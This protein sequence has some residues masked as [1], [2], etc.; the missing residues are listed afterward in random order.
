MGKTSRQ[1]VDEAKTDVAELVRRAVS[2]AAQALDGRDAAE[3]RDAFS[4][5]SKEAPAWTGLVVA[6]AKASAKSETEKPRELRQT[7]N[8]VMVGRDDT[9]AE[10]VDRAKKLA[11]VKK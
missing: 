3:V 8:V 4:L 11:A 7:L 5:P 6:V 10:W 1:I 9:T 2:M